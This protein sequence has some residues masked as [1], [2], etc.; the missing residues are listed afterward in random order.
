MPTKNHWFNFSQILCVTAETNRILLGSSDRKK[1]TG[2]C[3]NNAHIKT[4]YMYAVI[5]TR[6]TP[7]NLC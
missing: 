2:W 6:A 3:K 5:A 4:L 1:T 7:G